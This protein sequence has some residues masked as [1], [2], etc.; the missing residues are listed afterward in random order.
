M[1]DLPIVFLLLI[2]CGRTEPIEPAE[3]LL[4]PVEVVVPERADR[5]AG[6]WMVDQPYHAGYEVNFY[7]LG[8][9]GQ[10]ELVDS[11]GNPAP[12]TG[13]VTGVVSDSPT[14][15]LQCVFGASW[16]SVAGERLIIEGRCTDG[17]SRNIELG[18][19]SPAAQNGVGGGATVDLISVGGEQ[20]WIHPGFDWRFKKCPAG[21]AMVPSGRCED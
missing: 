19:T 8:A 20:G 3:T 13:P 21:P 5:F 15:A 12:A 6:L 4:P 2:G 1:R 7:A 18:F 17:S 14:A 16:H 11:F 9:D 10:V